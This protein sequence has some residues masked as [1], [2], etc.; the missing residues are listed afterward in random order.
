MSDRLF[1][2]QAKVTVFRLRGGTPGTFSYNNPQYFTGLTNA[3]EITDLRM[4]IKIE[5]NVDKEP[6]TGEVTITNL[7]ETTRSDMKIKPLSV[8]IDAGFD[9]NLRHL[10]RGDLRQ[11]FSEMKGADWETK[12]QLADGDRAYRY[13]RVNKSYKRGTK[14]SQILKDCASSMGLTIDTKTLGSPD[15]QN[16]VASGHVMLGSTRDEL[17]K[18]LAPFGYHWSIQNGKFIALRDEETSDTQAYVISEDTGMMNSPT[19]TTPDQ[20]GKPSALH[21]KSL[22]FPE[23]QPGGRIVVRSRDTNGTFRIEK[24]THTLDTMGTEALTE[25]E[26]KPSL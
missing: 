20:S 24:L 3:V 2:P 15:L 10:F 5:M 26:A 13:A 1:K 18:L 17:T 6:N 7:S 11:G 22:L 4:Q 8:E 16:A 12:L 19:W 23:L 25:I 14:L 9:G 21:V